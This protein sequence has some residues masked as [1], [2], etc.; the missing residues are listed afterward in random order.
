MNTLLTLIVFG[1]AFHSEYYAIFDK[2]DLKV[3][4]AQYKN[5]NVIQ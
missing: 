4:F 5:G 3:G 1:G 2:Q